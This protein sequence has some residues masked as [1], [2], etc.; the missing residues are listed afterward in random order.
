MRPIAMLN[1]LLAAGSL[2]AATSA[3]AADRPPA[4]SRDGRPNILILL[5]DDLGYGELSCQGNPQ[6]PTPHIDS[7]AANGVRCTS[8]YVTAPVCGP[9][10][11][12]LL[13]G[14]YNQRYGFEFNL[15]AA[16]GGLSLQ[17]RTMADR[18]QAAGYATGMFGKWHIGYTPAGQPTR[19]GFDW[20]FGFL[21]ACRSYRVP[22]GMGKSLRG[23]DAPTSNYMTD[24][25]GLEAA[26]F[27]EKNKDR[28]WLVYLPFGA[29]HASPQGGRKLVPADAGPYLAR[30][31]RIEPE[32]RRIFAGMMTGMDEAVG[33]V[34]A[35]LRELKLEDHT[36]IVFLGDNGGPT[37]QTTS[38]NDPLRG[39]KGDVLEGGIRVPFLVQWK[40]KLPAGRVEERP[41]IS[42]DILP[43]ALAAAGLPGDAELEGVNLLPS[44]AGGTADAPAR[45]LFWRYG[46]KRAVRTGDWKLT[47]Q[48]DGP[49]LYNLAADIGEKN[50]LS[51]KEP[52]KVRELLAAYEKWNAL[53]VPPKWGHAGKGPPS[54]KTE[55]AAPPAV[56]AAF[57]QEDDR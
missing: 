54:K 39:S 16:G 35:R 55:P 52:G 40:G 53:N 56:E 57:Q 15:G 28:P 50:D 43:T 34:L 7:L 22:P 44:L 42:L 23:E 46:A 14:R 24:L 21:P 3:G 30:F 17:A 47:D 33:T 1:A 5:A 45:S 32:Q 10:R 37:W 27:I 48:G 20:Y 4:T 6:I 9:S 13:T 25:L 18:L 19:R 2:A 51:A 41:V 38:R 29:V 11:A 26:A 8:G 31:S 36:L 12:G 49:R